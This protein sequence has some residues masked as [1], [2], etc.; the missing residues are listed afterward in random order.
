MQDKGQPVSNENGPP[1]PENNNN[2][3]PNININISPSRSSPGTN[4]IGKRRKRKTLN[5]DKQPIDGNLLFSVNNYNFYS[6]EYN[7][8][9]K[10][11]QRD[12]F[13]AA[14]TNDSHVKDLEQA[15]QPVEVSRS[16]DEHR[17]FDRTRN[18]YILG[19]LFSMNN[20][21]K[22]HE[23]DLEGDKHTTQFVN[24]QGYKQI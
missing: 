19:T 23:L 6:A 3:D 9:T 24:S 4:L 20:N 1:S 10:I 7:R 22:Q 18:S 14:I 5:L 11:E 12:N 16:S 17:F 2:A 13:K 21:Y 15:L 8:N